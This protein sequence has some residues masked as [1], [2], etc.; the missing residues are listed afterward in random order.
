ML[1]L[2]IVLGFGTVLV[3][4]VGDRLKLPW[5]ALMVFLGAVVALFP[6]VEG[7]EIDPELILPLFLPP[8]L[9]ATAQRTSWSMFRT[10]WR[11]ILFLAVGLV[12]AT[13]AV[14]T[15]TAM[16]LIP[17]ITVSAAIALGA[18]VSPP[19]P[20][21]VEAVSGSVPLPRRILQ[22][23]QSEGLFNDAA[24]LVIFQFAVAATLEG[25]ELDFGTLALNF[26]ISAVLAV[27]VGLV[28]PLALRMLLRFT[29]STI[30]RAASHLVLPFLVYLVAEH[31]HASG[32]IAVVVAALEVRRHDSAEQY[33]E[34]LMRRSTWQVLEMLITGIAFGLIGVEIRITI[35]NSDE[36]LAQAVGVGLVI[37]AVMFALRFAWLFLGTYLIDPKAQRGRSLSDYTKSTFIVAWGGMRGLATLALALALPYIDNSGA[38]FPA[39]SSIL[40]VIVVVL[41]TTLLAAGLTFPT[42]VKIL[43][44]SASAEHRGEAK[45]AARARRA[46]LNAIKRT[47]NVPEELRDE[48]RKRAKALETHLAGEDED[49]ERTETVRKLETYRHTFKRIQALSLNAARAEL[50]RARGEPGVDPAAVDQVLHRLDLQTAL[51]NEQTSTLPVIRDLGP[52]PKDS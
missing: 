32:V 42:L 49:Q 47:P 31:V 9:F 5:P 20:V 27:A 29:Q 13:V 37:S 40:V 18:M 26:G 36:N 28:L 2:L 52:G 23:L 4:G 22:V 14:V 44:V 16:W 35:L 12:G 11:T 46:S 34:R 38:A 41:A 17:G 43:G 7:I 24:A 8:L 21:A 10:R 39:R 3:V 50:L 25:E 6:G 19:D 30:A 51:L 1:I 45:I 15:A 48:M 33:E